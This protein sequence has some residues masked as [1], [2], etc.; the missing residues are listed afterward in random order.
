[1][2]QTI[3]NLIISLFKKT[4]TPK[5]ETKP[6]PVAEQKPKQVTEQEL[7]DA[8]VARAMKDVGK[9]EDKGPNRSLWIDIMNSWMSKIIGVDLT[10][11]AYCITGQQ[12]N[13]N[14]VCKELNLINPIFQTPSTQDFFRNGAVKKYIRPHGIFAK[15]GD[16]VSFQHISDAGKGHEGMVTENQINPMTFQTVEYNTNNAGSRAGDGCW[17]LKR[18][19]AGSANLKFQGFIDVVQ[20][21]LDANYKA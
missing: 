4:E 14:E 8:L 12:Y 17:T 21:I 3:I 13:L 15:K 16:W 19:T 10:G 5:Q 6:T 9:R 2:F 7:R 11:A 18:S 1:M 20:W